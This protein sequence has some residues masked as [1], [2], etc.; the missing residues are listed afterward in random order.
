MLSRGEYI[1]MSKNEVY[2]KVVELGYRPI[3]IDDLPGRVYHKHSHAETKIL[4]FVRGNMQVW[5]EG[6][7]YECE[8][9][10]RL[11][12]PGGKEHSAVVGDGGCEFWWGEKYL[13][14]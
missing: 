14:N 8:E 5:V 1:G 9:G 12:I 11:I 13:V 3:L 6:E 10:D 2:E 4:A 7:E